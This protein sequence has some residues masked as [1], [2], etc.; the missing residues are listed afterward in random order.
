MIGEVKYLADNYTR[1][2]IFA[3]VLRYNELGLVSTHNSK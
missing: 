1:L 3:T 2:F